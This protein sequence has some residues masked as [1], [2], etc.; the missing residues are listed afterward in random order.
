MN[1]NLGQNPVEKKKKIS[2][3]G[4]LGYSSAV[5]IS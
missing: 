1:V 5:A 3:F 2:R 4:N